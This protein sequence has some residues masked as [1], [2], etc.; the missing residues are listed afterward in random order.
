MLLLW[1]LQD[2]SKPEFIEQRRQALSQWLATLARIPRMTSNL[3]FLLFLGIT[4]EICEKVRAV[5]FAPSLQHSL[6]LQIAY[7]PLAECYVWQCHACGSAG[8][9]L[10]NNVV[11]RVCCHG[12]HILRHH[13]YDAFPF[14]DARG[15]VWLSFYCDHA[16]LS[17]LQS[18]I[19]QTG[20]LGM[21]LK[22][23]RVG[24][25]LFVEV[26]AF[27]NNDDGSRGQAELSHQISIGDK[28]VLL[29]LIA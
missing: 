27:K 29:C 11:D 20:A 7:C 16:V 9:V 5:L 19:F 21:T 13:I 6:P 25:E 24:A 26:T 28:C 12:P 15:V 23:Q 22:G 3:D 2:H 4:N 18:V 17:P 1:R 14:P 10:A 8:P